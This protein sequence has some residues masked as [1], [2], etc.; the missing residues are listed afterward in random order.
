MQVIVSP[1]GPGTTSTPSS[2]DFSAVAGRILDQLSATAWL[3]AALI[4]SDVGVAAAYQLASGSPAE[5]WRSIADTLNAKPF[6]V[7]LGV[8][9]ALVLVT[10]IT[11]SLEFAAIRFLEGYWGSSSLASTLIRF[12]IFFERRRRR[13]LT[14]T[15]DR[16]DRKALEA[17]LPAIR[18]QLKARP[19]MVAAIEWIHRG[20]DTSSFASALVEEAQAYITSR[21]WLRMA[22][23]HLIHRLNV[24]DA[25]AASFPS[26]DRMM[27][28][29]LGQALRSSED[30]L[31]YSDD[32]LRGYVIRNLARIN[33]LL[34]GEHDQYRN[35]LDMYAVM[36]LASVFLTGANIALLW[37]VV[38]GEGLATLSALTLLL[39]WASY[40]GAVASAHD[41]GTTLLAINHELSGGPER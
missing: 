23:T 14:R 33:P 39:A 20:D 24:I 22:P 4:V 1:A 18:T 16:L 38:A 10:I 29:R 36:C 17:A 6:G 26:E 5:R 12:G 3:P 28:S 8:S 31:E 37:H 19:T 40:R 27:P 11:Q 2:S 13:G 25:A 34:L 7:I 32:P 21:D 9:F 35:R 30:R 15:G 41:Y